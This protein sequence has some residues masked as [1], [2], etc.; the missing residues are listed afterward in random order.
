MNFK[1]LINNPKSFYIPDFDNHQVINNFMHEFNQKKWN[2]IK[3]T[4]INVFNIVK[5]YL[6]EDLK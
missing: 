1:Q 3:N 5:K 2:E 4:R 6:N